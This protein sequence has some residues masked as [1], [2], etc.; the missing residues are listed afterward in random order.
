MISLLALV[1]TSFH[2][3]HNMLRCT[4]SFIFINWINDLFYNFLRVPDK[5]INSPGHVFLK[6]VNVVLL[7]NL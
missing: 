2:G 1:K 5:R 6:G 4:D 7:V 3:P